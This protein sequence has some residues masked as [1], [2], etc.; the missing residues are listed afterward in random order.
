MGKKWNHGPKHGG[1]DIKENLNLIPVP[2]SSGFVIQ[3][4]REIWNQ[5]EL[6]STCSGFQDPKNSYYGATVLRNLA[7]GSY[8]DEV[9]GNEKKARGPKRAPS[10]SA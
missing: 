5:S 10:E 8:Y 9:G 3:L 1:K 7:N 6:C 4:S 2:S